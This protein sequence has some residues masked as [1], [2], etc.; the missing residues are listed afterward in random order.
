MDRFAEAAFAASMMASGSVGCAWIVSAEVLGERAHLDR[1]RASAMRSEAPLPTMWTPST[2]FVSRVDDDLHEAVGVALAM[3]RPSAANGNLPTLTLRPRVSAS[4]A[5]MPAVAISGSVK[6]TAGM[7]RTS[8]S[9]LWPGDDLGDDLGLLRRLVREHR[10]AARRR[11]W[12]RC[13]PR[14]CAAACRRGRSR[15]SIFTPTFSRPRLSE[16]GPPPDGDEHLVG[17][18][19]RVALPPDL[20]RDGG[21]VALLLPRLRLGAG[22]DLDAQLLELARDHAATSSGSLPGRMVG[23]ASTTVTLAPSFA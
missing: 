3:A 18:D 15:V 1:E 5:V 19:R 20:D 16:F 6:M 12:R 23:S 21:A 14:S 8:I 9:A 4:S 7:Q 17:V 22:H 2:S 10:L 11:R 13:R